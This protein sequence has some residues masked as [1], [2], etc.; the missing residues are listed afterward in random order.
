M[1][2]PRVAEAVVVRRRDA[3]WGEV[4]VAFVAVNDPT[5]SAE[6]LMQVCRAQLSSYKLPKE[7]RF[8][9][10]PDAFPRSTSGKVQRQ[11]VERWLEAD[12]S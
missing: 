3:E 11:L 6:A 10:S 2:D 5:A 7:I 9:D 4:P 8:V 1:A 12:P